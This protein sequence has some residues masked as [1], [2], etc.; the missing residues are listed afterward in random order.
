[1]EFSN[2][3]ASRAPTRAPTRF[4]LAR[5]SLAAGFAL[6]VVVASMIHAPADPFAKLG[7]LGLFGVDKWIHVGSY[8]LL[9]FLGAFVVLTR[10]VAVLVG[11]ALLTTVFG[12]G[13]EL[14]Q[15]TIEWRTMEFADVVANALGA[16]I[17]VALWRFVWPHLPVRTTATADA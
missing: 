11:I 16:V 3:L 6:A 12:A 2:A 14:L 1:M 7:P 5:F 9:A 17:A 10:S 8:A 15:G 13:V 4:A